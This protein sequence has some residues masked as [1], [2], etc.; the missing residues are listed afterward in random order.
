MKTSYDVLQLNLKALT[1]FNSIT[2]Y[3]VFANNSNM[4]ENV[5]VYMLHKLS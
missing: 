2:V 3:D 1:I 4:T 5:K